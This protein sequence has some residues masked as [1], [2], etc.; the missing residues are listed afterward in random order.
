MYIHDALKK[1]LYIYFS[2]FAIYYYATVTLNTGVIAY[3]CGGKS[4]NNNKYN[5]PMNEILIYDTKLS[6][7]DIKNVTAAKDAIP[8]P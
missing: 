2:Q 7:W 4:P 6:K 8:V 5:I 1:Y 3:I